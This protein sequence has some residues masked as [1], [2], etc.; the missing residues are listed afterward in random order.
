MTVLSAVRRVGGAILRHRALL[1]AIAARVAWAAAL[2]L[3]VLTGRQL[4]AIDVPL[5]AAVVIERFIYG[6]ALCAAVVVVGAHR[7]MRWAGAALGTAHA[8]FALLL[9]TIAGAA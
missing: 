2:W 4:A 7:R 3:L 1:I 5:D 8:G 9:W 6:I